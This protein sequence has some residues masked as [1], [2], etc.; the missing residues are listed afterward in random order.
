[1]SFIIRVEI[2][3]SLVKGHTLSANKVQLRDKN[4]AVYDLRQ[5]MKLKLPWGV[6]NCYLQKNKLFF[7]FSNAIRNYHCELPVK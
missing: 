2:R 1:M 5:S 6:N 7:F 4:G 3:Q